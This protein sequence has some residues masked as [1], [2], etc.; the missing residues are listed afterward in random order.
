ME[1]LKQKVKASH[2]FFLIIHTQIGV[3]VLSLPYTLSQASGADGWMSLILAGV[4]IQLLLGTFFLLYRRFPRKN[5]D[6]IVQTLLG[7]WIGNIARVF[8]LL[9]FFLI[10]VLFIA[11]LVRMLDRWILP[12]T[13]RVV[14]SLIILMLSFYLA[15]ES[16]QVILR[17]FLAV[18]PALVL[19][20]A[21]AT[22]SLK[23]ANIYHL[24]PIGHQGIGTI[25]KG[26]LDAILPL[27]GFEVILFLNAYITGTVKAKFKMAV[28]ANVFTLMLYLYLTLVCFLYFSPEEIAFLPEPMIYLIKSYTFQIIERTDLVFLSVWVV[29][30]FTSFVMFTF[31][32]GDILKSFFKKKK[33]ADRA[34]AVFLLAVLCLAAY[35][36]KIEE[37]IDEYSMYLTYSGYVLLLIPGLLYILSLCMRKRDDI[38]KTH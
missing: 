31:I 38:E 8:F 18:T 29:Y 7:N 30:I 33:R 17:F 16:L 20:V 37:R 12:E 2:V 13:P 25:F 9:F 26:S 23:D 28:W 11:I 22:Y 15:R 24:L 3:G 10:D 4:W 5:L 35:V 27:M 19:L 32:C 14:I 21:I 6:Q 1:I 36:W 34:L